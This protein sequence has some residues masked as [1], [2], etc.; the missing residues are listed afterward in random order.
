MIRKLKIPLK[1]FLIAVIPSILLGFNI[2]ERTPIYKRLIGTAHVER[3]VKTRLLTQY[4]KPGQLILKRGDDQNEFDSVWGLIRANSSAKLPDN[5]PYLISR[6]AVENGAFVTLPT[7][8]KAVL[9]PEATPLFAFFCP[10][11][12]ESCLDNEAIMVGSVGELG[13]WVQ[14]REKT[15]RLGIDIGVS[16]I[17]IFVGLLLELKNSGEATGLRDT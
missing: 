7:G 5:P 3:A 15:Y 11:P 14:E 10:R 8:R 12:T 13:K 4:D 9:I 16:L 17:S 2:L 1:I 6:V